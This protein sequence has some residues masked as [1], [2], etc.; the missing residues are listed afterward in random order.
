MSMSV[1]LIEVEEG[2]YVVGEGGFRTIE[3]VGIKDEAALA[4]IAC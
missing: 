2:T 1:L 3:V 4:T